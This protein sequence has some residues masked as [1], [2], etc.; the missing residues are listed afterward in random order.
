MVCL[1]STEGMKLAPDGFA[2]INV[3]LG[4]QTASRSTDGSANSGSG[5][6]ATNQHTTHS[7]NT[8]TNACAAQ[9]AASLWNGFLGVSFPDDRPIMVCL[10]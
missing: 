10:E 3:F 6:R 4:G 8:S 9:C 2:E 7:T 1:F 5:G